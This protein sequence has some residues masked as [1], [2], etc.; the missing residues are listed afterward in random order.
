MSRTLDQVNWSTLTSNWSQY[1]NF[2]KSDIPTAVEFVCYENVWMST[3]GLTTRST[4]TLFLTIYLSRWVA[5][6][7][8]QRRQHF[9]FI[10]SFETLGRPFFHLT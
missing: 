5:A 9:L 8:S 4:D 2:S 10:A 6:A 1:T 3:S 7:D